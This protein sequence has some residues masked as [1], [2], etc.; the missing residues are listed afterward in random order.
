[1]FSINECKRS[2]L[3]SLWFVFSTFPLMV[4]RV[5]SIEKIISWRWNNMIYVAVGSFI[6][7]YLFRMLMLKKEQQGN[8]KKDPEE[9]CYLTF[10][11][12]ISSD[13]K[14]RNILAGALLCFALIFPHTSPP[15][16]PMS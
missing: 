14:Q 6:L 15:T 2:L 8:G 3:A 5:D 11:Q 4:V 12:G 1:M 10:L 13:P 16:K 7:S 9:T